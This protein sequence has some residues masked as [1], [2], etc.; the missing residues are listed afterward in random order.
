MPLLSSVFKGNLGGDL[1][2]LTLC[3][4]CPCLRPKKPSSDQ[5]LKELWSVGVRAGPW[6][7]S[8]LRTSLDGHSIFQKAKET[9]DWFPVRL[10]KW[11]EAPLHPRPE[12]LGKITDLPWEAVEVVSAVRGGQMPRWAP[13]WGRRAN[14]FLLPSPAF[15]R[16]RG[17]GR[18]L[19]CADGDPGRLSWEKPLTLHVQ[20]RP[21]FGQVWI[22]TALYSLLQHFKHN[23]C[24]GNLTSACGLVKNIRTAVN[25]EQYRDGRAIRSQWEG[26]C[27]GS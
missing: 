25:W 1:H 27:E 23:E 14:G 19:P 26:V 15:R 13:P 16:R 3:Q 17:L 11:W 2:L 6:R 4:F 7:S 9:A 5:R 20:T 12:H 22:S 8:E 21:L 24:P 10:P 18:L